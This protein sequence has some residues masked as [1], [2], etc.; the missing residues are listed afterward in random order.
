MC[1]LEC[2]VGAGVEDADAGG[3]AVDGVDAVDNAG[4]VG[5]EAAVELGVAGLDAVVAVAAVAGVV[6]AVKAC[7]GAGVE[8]SSDVRESG[9]ED[10]DV[11]RGQPLEGDGIRRGTVRRWGQ[12]RQ[13]DSM[14]SCP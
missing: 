12:C 7:S 8:G 4:F 1:V 11:Q 2:A 13:R 14:E 5:A 6:E 3:Y 9:G 10:V